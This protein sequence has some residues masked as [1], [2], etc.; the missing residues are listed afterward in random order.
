MKLFFC[1]KT[2]ETVLQGMKKKFLMKNFLIFKNTNTLFKYLLVLTSS[3]YQQLLSQK[4]LENS[5]C[6]H[7]NIL[8]HENKKKTVLKYWKNINVLEL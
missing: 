3:T 7:I 6:M 2:C 8:K 5:K 1:K 4:E